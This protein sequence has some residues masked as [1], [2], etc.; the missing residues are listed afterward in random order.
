PVGLEHHRDGGDGAADAAQRAVLGDAADRIVAPL[1]VAL[2]EGRQRELHA[3][4]KVTSTA[5]RERSLPNPI[6]VKPREAG[7][8]EQDDN[9]EETL[10]GMKCKG[11]RSRVA[12][13]SSRIAQRLTAG[14]TKES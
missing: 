14:E 10:Q 2:P 6:D 1:V 11:R 4:E 8:H 12:N 7:E 5:R 9:E 13:A 3:V